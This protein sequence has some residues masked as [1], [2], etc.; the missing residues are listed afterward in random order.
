MNLKDRKIS[1]FRCHIS[2]Q[3]GPMPK[4]AF[5]KKDNPGA[6]FELTPVGIYVKMKVSEGAGRPPRWEEYLVPFSNIQNMK[7]EPIPESGPTLPVP[8][9]TTVVLT[10]GAVLMVPPEL[11]PP[12]PTKKDEEKPSEEKPTEPSEG[13]SAPDHP[14]PAPAQ[15][16]PV[17]HSK[18]GRAKKAP[19]NK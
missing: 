17:K 8:P 5:S 13:A 2:P 11:L 16:S 3:I 19:D 9:A 7:L 18:E 15:E 12:V 10:P 14:E 4:Q 1:Q 6:E